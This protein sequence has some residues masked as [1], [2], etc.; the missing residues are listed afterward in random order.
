MMTMI[1]LVSNAFQEFSKLLACAYNQM[2]ME[3]NK[4]HWWWMGT[5]YASS[6]FV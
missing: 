2:F 3:V 1:F 5:K 6:S 4:I